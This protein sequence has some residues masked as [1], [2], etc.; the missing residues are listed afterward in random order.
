M[1]I[2][3]PDP[4]ATCLVTGASSGI[5][6][7][8]AEQLAACGH[9]VTIVAR[10]VSRLEELA[11]RLRASYGVEID[12][13]A[14]DLSVEPRRDEL[15]AAV[16]ASG[17]DVEVLINNAGFGMVGAWLELDAER[18]RQMVRLIVDAPLHLCR[19][20]IPGMVSRRRGAVLNLGSIVSF[21][22][23][24]HFAAYSAA[25]AFSLSFTSALHA[26]LRG[27]GVT[28]TQCCPGPVR[29]E[30]TEVTGG[31]AIA[32]SLPD[33]CWKSADE[34]ASEALAALD[35]GR[36]LLVPGWPTRAVAFAGH[37]APRGPMLAL[38]SRIMSS[39]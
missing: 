1:A 10:R 18:E 33:F 8:F 21:M 29:T 32:A 22:P 19:E 37:H 12:V 38:S 34:V 27:T 4:T 7:A 17:R 35:S 36:R 6:A 24:P 13:V 20:L 30:F 14:C 3:A 2:P 31:D 26:E 16:R 25:K 5:G 9:N 23:V 39:G 15:L 11:G 28:V